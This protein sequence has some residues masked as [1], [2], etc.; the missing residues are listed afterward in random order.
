V[1]VEQIRVNAPRGTHEAPEQRRHGEREPGTPTQVSE[2]TVPVGQAEVAKLLRADDLDDD[3]A[4]A[5][6][7]DRVGDEASDDVVRTPWVRRC[8]NRNLHERSTRKTA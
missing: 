6:M 7:L 3:A 8:K 5:G 1:R 2:D 4:R